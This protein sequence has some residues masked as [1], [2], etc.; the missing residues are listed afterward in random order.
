MKVCGDRHRHRHSSRRCMFQQ[1]HQ[2]IREQGHL[3]NRAGN[4]GEMVVG[5]MAVAMVAMVATVA[6]VA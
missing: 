5:D 2:C 6:I 4:S 1:V 3:C